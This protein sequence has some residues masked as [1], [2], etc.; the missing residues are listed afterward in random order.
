MAPLFRPEEPLPA[1][2]LVGQDFHIRHASFA[3]PYGVSTALPTQIPA[4][5]DSLV[6]PPL[7]P[8]SG[9]PTPPETSARRYSPAPRLSHA[10]RRR[11]SARDPG[12]CS[13]YGRV[14]AGPAESRYKNPR[15]RSSRPT[16]VNPCER[17][18]PAVL[19]QTASAAGDFH[20]WYKALPTD[21][22]TTASGW[23]PAAVVRQHS[24]DPTAAPPDRPAPNPEQTYAAPLPGAY[25]K[26][27]DRLKGRAPKPTNRADRD[28]EPCESHPR[29]APCQKFA[30]EEPIRHSPVKTCRTPRHQS[31]PRTIVFRP[32]Q[33]ISVCRHHGRR[34]TRHLLPGRRTDLGR[35][36]S[37]SGAA[38][39]SDRPIR[40]ESP[41]PIYPA[42]PHGP[43]HSADQSTSIASETP[44]GVRNR[45]ATQ[46][47]R[48]SHCVR[49]V[50][51]APRP[52]PAA[53]K[54]PWDSAP[55]KW[56]RRDWIA[57]PVPVPP[58]NRVPARDTTDR[59]KPNA[60]ETLRHW[61]HVPPGHDPGNCSSK[62]HHTTDRQPSHPRTFRNIK[63]DHTTATQS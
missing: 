32:G 19:A 20:S 40:P 31:P 12:G 59:R 6:P 7:P 25:V 23:S 16:G 29:P 53:A 33:S 34:R 51:R 1:K 37:S 46:E 10:T 21:R 43:L 18:P 36:R 4:A 39:H 14:T 56:R 62:T 54:G 8:E 41:L 48:E 5:A 11:S 45:G 24:R 49:R 44:R 38:D 42:R 61:P 3:K 35:G 13:R 55:E 63:T 28:A 22:R 17:S 9:R 52:V 47:S 26:D 60:G 50:D 27:E 30:N 58:P 15:E 57:A 2:P